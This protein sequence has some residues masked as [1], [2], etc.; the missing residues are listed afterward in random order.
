MICKNKKMLEFCL[1]HT[2]FFFKF[3]HTYG[4]KTSNSEFDDQ[5][6]ISLDAAIFVN[7]RVDCFFSQRL[8]LFVFNGGVYFLKCKNISRLALSV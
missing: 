2:F 8:S 3:K 4:C 7:P 6:C 1:F 5:G